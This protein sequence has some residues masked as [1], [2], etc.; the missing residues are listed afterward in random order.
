MPAF[1]DTS[2]DDLER[3]LLETLRVLKDS[4]VSQRCHHARHTRAV[5]TRVIDAMA[6]NP[7]AESVWQDAR[8][9]HPGWRAP[10]RRRLVNIWAAWAM[11]TQDWL[12]GLNIPPLDQARLK[13]AIRQLVDASAPSNS[14]FNPA[15]TQRLK[16]TSGRCLRDGLAHLRHDIATRHPLPAAHAEDSFMVG[17]DLATTPGHIV[18]RTPLFELIQ[19]RPLTPAVHEAP[20]LVIPPPLNRY[21]FLDMEPDDSLI[22]YALNQGLQVFLISWRNP[23]PSHASWGLNDYVKAAAAALDA[24]ST[25]ACSRASI[26]GVCSGGVIG[27]GL[28]GLLQ[29]QGIE[30]RIQ[31]A[32]YLATPVQFRQ[33]SELSLL[34]SPAIR[35][36]VRNRAWRQG[37]IGHRQLA[38][39]F[40]WLR[41]G[42]LVWPHMQ[43][44]VL[45]QPEHRDPLT[46]WSQDSTRL[47]AQMVHDLLDLLER[48]ALNTPGALELQGFAIQLHKLRTPSWHLG[49]ERDHIVPW[50]NAFPGEGLGGNKTFTLSH[51]GHIQSLV[52]PPDHPSAW[53]R[54]APAITGES[55]AQWH[56]GSKQQS[57]SW[58]P[59]WAGWLKG[60]SGALRQAPASAGSADYPA[61]YPAP[62]RY[63][64]QL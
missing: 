10:L 33:H 54:S 14:P 64:H 45:A 63:V 4:A 62:G 34:A 52:N 55:I 9:A 58:W 15:L 31:S 7:S 57:G 40:A 11:Q 37:C 8:F 3:S 28:Q 51:G 26:L 56:T 17:R 41:P 53:F 46:F 5:L 35:Q 39:A 1:T 43:R 36:R 47:P 24:T 12:D 23:N 50:Q 18:H 19:Y 13:L 48:D 59:L 25:I 6:D 61:H 29:A 49:A 22:R 42:Q 32:S 16:E 20:L 60:L 21:Y 38:A 2:R 44:Y 27:L 30:D